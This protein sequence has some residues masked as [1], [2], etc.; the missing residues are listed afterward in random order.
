MDVAVWMYIS[1]STNYHIAC[2]RGQSHF[3]GVWVHLFIHI[4]TVGDLYLLN[5]CFARFN[6]MNYVILPCPASQALTRN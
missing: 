2:K 4:Y 5:R 3:V 1:K 6:D